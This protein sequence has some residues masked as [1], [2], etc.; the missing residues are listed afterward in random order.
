MN[1]DPKHWS[2][3]TDSFWFSWKYLSE[4]ALVVLDS[5]AE[6]PHFVRVEDAVLLGPVLRCHLAHTRIE[7]TPAYQDTGTGLVDHTAM[8]MSKSLGSL[9]L[10]MWGT[11]PLVY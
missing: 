11:S 9:V 1:P 7:R 8:H 6:D 5:L 10:C 4:G 2:T 3:N